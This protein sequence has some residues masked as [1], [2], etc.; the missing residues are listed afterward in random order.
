MEQIF[1]LKI[2]FSHEGTQQAVFPTLIRHGGDLILVDCG[3]PGFLPLLET[4]IQAQGFSPADLTH[5]VI[6]HHDDDHMGALAELLDAY[7]RIQVLSGAEEAPYISGE[8]KSLR[9]QQAEALQPTLPPEMQAWGLAFQQ[10]LA[11]VRPARVDVPLSPGAVLPWCGGCQVL[12]TP[13]HM[14]GHIS[15]YFPQARTVITGNAAVVE[16]QALALA[17]PQF[18]LDMAAAQTSLAMLL[19]LPADTYHCFH[20]G[21]FRRNP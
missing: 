15:L 3:H 10:R 2:S 11:V 13:G 17:N 4:A 9:L 12:A 5:V 20:G 18:T 1:P 21:T 16:G 14:S 19:A 7:P 6:T 8:K